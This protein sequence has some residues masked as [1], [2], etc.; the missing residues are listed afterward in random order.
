MRCWAHQ[1]HSSGPTGGFLPENPGGAS[2][3]SR[4]HPALVIYTPDE[5]D[6]LIGD[7]DAAG[8]SAFVDELHY[9]AT[10]EVEALCPWDGV[11]EEPPLYRALWL[12]AAR[13]LIADRRKQLGRA[14]A[15]QD[16][17]RAEHLR[18]SRTTGNEHGDGQGDGRPTSGPSR[19][20]AEPL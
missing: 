20:V 14:E 15:T 19:D 17:P 4:W 10:E 6:E 3:P 13:R 9:L 2:E 12:D 5:Q 1:M 8:G 18:C 7:A 11:G 16:G